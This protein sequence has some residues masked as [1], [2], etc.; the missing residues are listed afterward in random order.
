[1]PPCALNESWEQELP[2]AGLCT[3]FMSAS[4]IGADGLSA[5]QT[6]ALRRRQRSLLARR[7]A[8]GLVG[9]HRLS[10]HEMTT[11]WAAQA[12]A[13]VR[14]LTLLRPT[15]PLTHE[16]SAPIPSPARIHYYLLELKQSAFALKQHL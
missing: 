15:I 12:A 7:R 5:M 8:A 3:E 14:T 4:V 16:T 11:R 10:A 9:L 6:E 1:M 2:R 13:N